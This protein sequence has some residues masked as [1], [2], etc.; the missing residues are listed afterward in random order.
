MNTVVKKG[1]KHG[2]HTVEHSLSK[3]DQLLV[4]VSSLMI[5]GSFVWAPSLFIYLYKK[6]KNTPKEDVKKRSLY[7][8]L[9]VAL[10]VCF[11]VGPHRHYKV[12]QWLKFHH[13]RMWEAWV[14]YVSFQVITEDGASP[15]QDYDFKKDQAI[16]AF[17]PH[18]IVPFSLGMAAIPAMA[19]EYFGSFR[20]VAATA[21]RLLP[22]M[23][24]VM[25]YCN[26]VDA[27]RN[28]IDKVLAQG[29]S[30]GISPGGI[31]EMFEGY[32]KAGRHPDEECIVLNGR[33]GFVK[34]ALKHGV[35]LVPIYTFGSSKF[36]KRFQI[37]FFEKV[38]NMLRI[39]L[40]LFY[41]R[42]GLPIPLR[43]KFLYVI[44]APIHPPSDLPQMG[45]PEFDRQV[46]IMH[47]KFCDAMTKLFEKYKS[48]YGWDHK[49]L[50]IV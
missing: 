15:S 5:V 26:D 27:S 49:T 4:N 34:M 14:R 45:T 46:D 10:S 6:W 25:V 33:K 39:S 31:A 29:E 8:N 32:P 11:I 28:P 22:L 50:R 9:L 16:L 12:G 2:H 23:R 21:T 41:G 18:G 47:G 44:G 30:I 36:L 1:S 35:P 13:W 40:C 7:R 24:S 42:S 43:K 19:K 38:S 17:A 20:L 48:T 3:V 37:P